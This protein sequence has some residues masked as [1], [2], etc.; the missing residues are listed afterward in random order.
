MAKK[1]K[2]TGKSTAEEVETTSSASAQQT[3]NTAAE[4]NNGLI[5]LGTYVSKLAFTPSLAELAKAQTNLK[6]AAGTVERQVW[7]DANGFVHIEPLS[8]NDLALLPNNNIPLSL[9]SYLSLG[10]ARGNPVKDALENFIQVTGFGARALNYK[11]VHAAMQDF[12]HG[13]PQ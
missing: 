5:P 7:L 1:K 9:I 4:A 2:R 11:K 3:H 8:D 6:L 10:V 12:L 13:F